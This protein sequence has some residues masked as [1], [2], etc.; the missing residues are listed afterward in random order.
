[1]LKMTEIKLKYPAARIR[2]LNSVLAKKDTTL[3]NEMNC[4]HMAYLKHSQ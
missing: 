1:M 4:L 2:A 3:D